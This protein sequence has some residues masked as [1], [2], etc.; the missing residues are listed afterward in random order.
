MRTTNIVTKKSFPV[1]QKM[2]QSARYIAYTVRN[3]R[4]ERMYMQEVNVQ[5]V[6]LE[7]LIFDEQTWYPSQ[8]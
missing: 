4:G 5:G 3:K 6:D 1:N 2:A 7:D 8:R